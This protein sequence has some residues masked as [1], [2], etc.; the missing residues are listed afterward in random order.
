MSWVFLTGDRAYKLK[1]PVTTPFLDHSTLAARRL[2]C[3]AELRLNQRLAPGVYLRTVPLTVG[4]DGNLALDQ[5]G[6]TVDWLVVMRRL[7]DGSLLQWQLTH[8]VRTPSAREIEQLIAHLVSFYRSSAGEPMSPDRY[9]NHLLGVL[10]LDRAELLRPERALD[11]E[12][13]ADLVTYLEEL[14]IGAPVL[15]PRSAHVVDGHGDLRPEHIVVRPEPL[16]IDRI[17]ADRRLRLVDPAYDLALLAV[18]CEHLGVPSVGD[19][20]LAAYR[21]EADDALPPSVDALY[22]CLRATTRARLS[23]AHLGDGDRDAAKWLD[24][25]DS[26]LAIA[27]RHLRRYHEE[28]VAG[29]DVDRSGAD[30]SAIELE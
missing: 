1:K 11:G 20:M 15:G 16:V 21:T 10:R 28:A 12:E 13:I 4:S 5:P 18:E 29:S 9:R 8:D 30:R 7:P 23:L 6:R 17:T 2:D 24:R 25:T 26:Y 3:H 22:R 19:D 14:L 27:G